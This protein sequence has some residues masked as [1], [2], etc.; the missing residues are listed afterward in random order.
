MERNEVQE[1]AGSAWAIATELAAEAVVNGIHEAAEAG[2]ELTMLQQVSM[3]RGVLMA[4]DG[5]RVKL[6]K[7][8]AAHGQLEQLGELVRAGTVRA[9]RIADAESDRRWTH[10]PVNDQPGPLAGA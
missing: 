4:F 7:D 10:R 1:L 9:Q 6:E 5:A 8:F 2:R 3:V